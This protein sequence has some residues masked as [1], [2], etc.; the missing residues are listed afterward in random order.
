MEAVGYTDEEDTCEQIPGQAAAKSVSKIMSPECVRG[1][2]TDALGE[3]LG[4]V[5]PDAESLTL[6]WPSGP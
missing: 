4:F 6:G 2:E 1:E 5:L 3:E